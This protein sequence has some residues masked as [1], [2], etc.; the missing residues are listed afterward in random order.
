MSGRGG[1]APGNASVAVNIVYPCIDDLRLNLIAPDG[2]VYLLRSNS[3]GAA[4]TIVEA[5]TRKLSSE[6]L[7][8]SWKLRTVDNAGRNVGYINRWTIT[9]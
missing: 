7:D 8:G 2:S 3:G 1:N 5:Y 9:F 6:A 4:A